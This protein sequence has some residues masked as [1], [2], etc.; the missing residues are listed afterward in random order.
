ME[1]RNPRRGAR[2]CGV[3]GNLPEEMA[4]WFAAHLLHN[5]RYKN[6]FSHVTFAVLD[7]KDSG[8]FAAFEQR[9]GRL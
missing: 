2:G 3:F 6:A 8:T 4:G 9:F 7:R 5:P 1:I